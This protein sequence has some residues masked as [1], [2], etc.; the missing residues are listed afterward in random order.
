MSGY[1][2]FISFVVIVA[3]AMSFSLISSYDVCALALFLCA[4]NCGFMSFLRAAS[5]TLSIC[6]IWF[7]LVGFRSGRL[8]AA[9]A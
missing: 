5:I 2:V 8:S 7:C 1:I 9:I 3:P 6:S 4:V